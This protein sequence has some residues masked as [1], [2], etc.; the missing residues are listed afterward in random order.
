MAFVRQRG[1]VRAREPRGRSRRDLAAG[2]RR[3]GRASTRT[4]LRDR[5]TTELSG[6]EL[7]RV[8]L[9]SALALEPELLLLDEP[10]SQLDPA[11]AEGFL[12]A[13]EDAWA[14][15]R[16]L[17]AARRAR[18]VPR[19]AGAVRRGR[20]PAPRCSPRGSRSLAPSEPPPLRRHVPSPRNDK[21]PSN[22]SVTRSELDGRIPWPCAAV[23][24]LTGV[25]FAHRAGVPVLDGVDLT[26]AAARSW[27]SRGRTARG[28][29]RSRRSPPACSSPRAAPITRSG[30][31]GYLL[32][33][34]GRYLVRETV[35]DEVALAVGGDAGRAAT[36]LERVGLAQLADRHPRDLSSGERERLGVAAVAVAEPDLLVLDE[37]TRGL[38]P[39]RK[40]A[41]ADWLMAYAAAGRG[42]LVATH[43][44]TLPGRPA[45][46][47]RAR[48]GGGPC[49][50]RGRS[51]FAAA[52]V[53]LA[54]ALWAALDPGPRQLLRA[55]RRHRR[56]RRRRRVARGRAELGQGSDPRRD[57]RRAGGGRPRALRRRSRA[58]SR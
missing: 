26:C 56:A 21:R 51:T 58:C 33:D 27:R 29:R 43:D 39:D 24:S 31:A 2:R 50:A 35:L 18:P 19:H 15:R 30:R 13:V 14:R 12:G 17:G 22:S 44:R 57:A 3:A 52:A 16:P 38:D 46:L 28:R 9:A 49:V 1:R 47:A 41:L 7:Q 5:R 10:T 42:V 23:V 25:S 45:G 20:P 55:P 37:P 8:C 6:G 54:A 48:P 11:A 36:A 32:Q 40:A 4:H 53:A 34:P